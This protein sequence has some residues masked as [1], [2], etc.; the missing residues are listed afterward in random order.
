MRTFVAAEL[1]AACRDKLWKAIEIL[2]GQAGGVRW[3]KPNA[4]HLTLKFIG[5]LPETEVPTALAALEPAAQGAPPFSMRVAGISGFPARGTPSVIFAR[6]EE[7]TG[8]LVALQAAIDAAL[9]EHLGVERERRRYVPHITLGR[10]KDRR[11]CPGV[12][13]LA[14]AVQ[15]DQFGAVDVDSVV[16]MK[17]DLTPQGAIYTPLRRFALRG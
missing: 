13:L 6:V 7:T 14:Q 17:S 9:N 12:E 5:Q 16:L 4:L 15:D 2:R 8:S 1:D 11:K 3:V 10:V